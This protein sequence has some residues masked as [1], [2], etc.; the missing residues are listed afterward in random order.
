MFMLEVNVFVVTANTPLPVR[1]AYSVTR[2]LWMSARR[3]FLRECDKIL[4]ACTNIGE[5]RLFVVTL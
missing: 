1:T 5:P 3:N 2:R 4:D